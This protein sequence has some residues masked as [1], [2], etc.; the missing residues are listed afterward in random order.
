[1][2]YLKLTL[3]VWLCFLC[4]NGYSQV[5]PEA[6]KIEKM[7]AGA[8]DKAMASSVYIIEWDTLKNTVKEGLREKD[9]FTGVAVSA[10]GHILTASHAAA[11]G[12]VYQIRFPDGSMHIAKGMGRIGIKAGET[13]HDIAMIKILKIGKWPFAEMGRVANLKLNQ[14]VISIS[15]PNSFFKV[16]PNVRFGRLTDI[17]SK[18]G[19]LEST[20]KMEPG[21]S[22][23]PLFDAHGRVIGIHSWIKEIESVNFDVPIDFYLK[24]WTALDQPVDY[25]E[26]PAASA[27]SPAPSPDMLPVPALEEV[28][29]LSAQQCKSTVKLLSKRG[30]KEMSVLGTLIA[31][32]DVVRIVS[33]SSMVASMPVIA[34]DGRTV[35]LQV[36]ARDRDNDLVL[37]STSE[38]FGNAIQLKGDENDP[39]LRNRD[40]GKIFMTAVGGDRQKTGILSAA[41]IDLP[42]DASFGY[43]GANAVYADGKI[44]FSRVSRSGAGASVLKPGDQVVKINNAPVFKAVDY[45]R[46]MGK[47]LAGDSITLDLIR[48][49]KP[50]NVS[51]FLSGQP[52][53]QHVSFEYPGGRSDRSD[54]F[55]NVIVHD[56]PVQADECGSPVF[57]IN[58]RF[59]GINIARRSRTSSIIMPAGIIAN[60]IKNNQ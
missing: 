26:L 54:G 45:D 16:T 29:R 13:D 5:S 58:G 15:Y 22:G 4:L 42:M 1:M 51:L 35:P 11:T 43:T 57:D 21:D 48:E 8:V 37:L 19:F 33:K 53:L 40:L 31:S 55:K 38:K 44:T 36:V 10:Q 30:E 59:W 46:E 32:N 17:D 60:F 56:T 39:E 25:Q 50:V 12:E 28:A 23:G 27:I 14:P 3:P 24:Y 20:A 34:L 2:K 52:K 49:E 9:G 6:W 47:Y 18:D 7:I 41:Y